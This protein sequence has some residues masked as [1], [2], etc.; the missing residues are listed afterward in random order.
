[1][2][3]KC[4]SKTSYDCGLMD[5]QSRFCNAIN[6]ES[7]VTLGDRSAFTLWCHTSK[8]ILSPLSQN[9]YFK[10][11]Y[12]G[13]ISNES[14]I[15]S[16]SKNYFATICRYNSSFVLV[17]SAAKVS[18]AVT[19]GV[20]RFKIRDILYHRSGPMTAVY[21]RSPCK[22]QLYFNDIDN[23]INYIL[24]EHFNHQNMQ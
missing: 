8:A 15:K 7:E 4:H 20:Y 23:T 13:I 6:F 10:S 5:I 2:C 16:K 11:L 18:K 24:Q 19:S 3:N 21:G 9:E 14:S 17:S 22:A 1:M 12:D